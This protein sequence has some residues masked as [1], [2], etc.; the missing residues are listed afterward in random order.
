[1][2]RAFFLYFLAFLLSVYRCGV[3]PC[4]LQC[5]RSMGLK[6]AINILI[7]LTLW[8]PV[9][10]CG[11]LWPSVALCGSLWLSVA[12]CGSLWPSVAFLLGVK[13]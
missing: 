8:P 7:G 13:A 11:P 3:Y 9:A 6:R 4:N 2:V 1:M 10:L 12:L 5:K